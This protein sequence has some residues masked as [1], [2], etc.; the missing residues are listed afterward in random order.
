MTT[1]LPVLQALNL[2][3]TFAGHP[4]LTLL[5]DVSLTLYPKEAVAIVGKS[6]SGKSSLLHIL[7][8]LDAPTKG[9]VLFPRAPDLSLELIR[10]LHVGFVFQSFH[11]LEDYTLLE[12]VIMPGKIAK[13]PIKMLLD[14]AFDLLDQVGL[15]EKKDMPVKLLSGGEKQRAS[16]A[17]S[18]CNDPD[19]LLVDEPTGNLDRVNALMVQDLLLQC[20]KKYG[21][22]LI[23]V[24]HDEDFAALCDKTY[25]LK[26]GF[27]HQ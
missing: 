15:L 3:K 21:K 9:K 23:L 11:L 5:E 20:C 27:L 4:P 7:G 24:T 6:G 17:R 19:I 22:A 2:S 18:L 14:R 10:S 26:D 16:L 8:T 1:P 13:M 12:N 25:H